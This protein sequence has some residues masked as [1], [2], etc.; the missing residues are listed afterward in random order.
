MAK[1]PG[2]MVYFDLLETL[3]LL[4]DK[5]AGILFRAILHYGQNQTVPQ[6][7]G[8]LALLWP[9]I[10]MRL[11][12]DN[13]RYTLTSQRRKYAVYVRWSKEHGQTPLSFNS[14]MADRMENEDG[15]P[16]PA[17]A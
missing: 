5:N 6:L 17:M 10:Q 2:V 15:I 3:E 8:R 12:L 16:L 9:M 13:E 4:S 11:D 1:K 14:W 7:P